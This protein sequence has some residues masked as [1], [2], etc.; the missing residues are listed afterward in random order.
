MACLLA[1]L[2]ATAAPAQA[3]RTG[4]SPMTSGCSASGQTLVS[5]PVHAGPGGP[6]GL[7]QVRWSKRCAAAWA[8]FIANGG[9]S[10]TFWL[11]L[12]LK[13]NEHNDRPEKG[14]RG[15][16]RGR[17][18]TAMASAPQHGRVCAR[19]T[20][21]GTHTVTTRCVAIPST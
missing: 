13:I 12:I 20:W 17:T 16:D 2:L 7:L 5:T 10:P 15:R 18:Y 11:R 14:I 19:L 1:L 8:R 6:S 4:A 9:P 3:G 21:S